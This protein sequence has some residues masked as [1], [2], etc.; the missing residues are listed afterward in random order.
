MATKTITGAARRYLSYE[1]LVA[2][3]IR[4]LRNIGCRSSEEAADM[5]AVYQ[6][7]EGAS[8]DAAV[9][10]LMA[11][12]NAAKANRDWHSS[13]THHEGSAWKSTEWSD[14]YGAS[15]GVHF[16]TD[17]GVSTVVSFKTVSGYGA[18]IGITMDKNGDIVVD[19]TT[20]GI[21]SERFW[22]GYASGDVST[23]LPDDIREAR[24]EYLLSRVLLNDNEAAAAD[25]A[26]AE[27]MPPRPPRDRR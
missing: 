24:E 12:A 27:P 4:E 19:T 17:T 16:H 11:F 1:R 26:S 9:A 14:V 10:A 23:G 20:D 22:P 21:E 7:A 2:N 6:M 3:I 8:E 18:D 5:L 15:A 13:E 25:E